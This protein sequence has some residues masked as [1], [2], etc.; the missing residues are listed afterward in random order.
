M[1]DA[2]HPASLP[3]PLSDD[4]VIRA[5]VPR[6]SAPGAI[7]EIRVDERTS[8]QAEHQVVQVQHVPFLGKTD[9][10]IIQLPVVGDDEDALLD[11][12]TPKLADEAPVHFLVGLRGLL[13][14]AKPL[15]ERVP[16]R[17]YRRAR[18]R[19]SILRLEIWSFLLYHNVTLFT[20]SIWHAYL[21]LTSVGI[22]CRGISGEQDVSVLDHVRYRALLRSH[23][24]SR[25]QAGLIM[26]RNHRMPQQQK[27]LHQFRS[28]SSSRTKRK[29]SKHLARRRRQRQTTKPFPDGNSLSALRYMPSSTHQG[30]SSHRRPLPSMSFPIPMSRSSTWPYPVPSLYFRRRPSSLQYGLL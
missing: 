19:A 6:S 9:R 18:A 30:S 28:E 4:F 5:I 8:S 10:V 11:I 23:A 21:F 25:L 3:Y 29:P 2:H 20:C 1:R 24:H 22:Y 26:G 17:G 15:T 16:D 27:P 14:Q 12:E 7:K 13:L